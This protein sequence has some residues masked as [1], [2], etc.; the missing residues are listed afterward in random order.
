MPR[1]IGGSGKA[2]ALLSLDASY[3]DS[4]IRDLLEGQGVRDSIG[5]S[6]QWVLLDDFGE[7]EKVPLEA[8]R[9]RVEPFDPRDDGYAEKLRSF[10]VSRGKRRLFIP[11]R[12][13]M[14]DRVGA[15]LKNIPFSLEVLTAPRSLLL[16]ALLFLVAAA[17]TL[18][19]SAAPLI[20]ALFLPLWAVLAGMGVPGF[21]LIAAQ[22]AL[23]RLLGEPVREYFISR[24]YEKAA[25]ATPTEVGPTSVGKFPAPLATEFPA[26]GGSSPASLRKLFNYF[27]DFWVLG[28]VFLGAC[29]AIAILGGLGPLIFLLETVFFLFLLGLSLWSESNRGANQG[30]IRFLP[31]QITDIALKPPLY[32]RIL[33][34]FALA[35]LALLFLGPLFNASSAGT[36]LGRGRDW[37]T[38]RN[39]NAEIYRKHGEFQSQFSFLP[40]YNTAPGQGSGYGR[41]SLGTDGLIA[42]LPETLVFGETVASSVDAI[43]PFPLEG[44]IDFLD[45][46]SY[47]DGGMVSPAGGVPGGSGHG[48]L[49]SALIGLGLCIPLIFWDRRGHSTRGKLSKYMDKRIAA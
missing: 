49:F 8:Y 3:P 19:F 25:L 28:A 30:H 24:R 39:I 35:S 2:Y 6:T 1:S 14:E 41:Y 45:H 9:D 13:G 15:A 48:D 7:M 20:T 47:T 23:S 38:R 42:G 10:F 32:S 29:G 18:F 40:L 43:P 22:A 16:P 26:Q 5:E 44:L 21:A 34:P 11:L 33:F 27:R 46:Y 37:D 31:V 12:L 36:S 17:I 4:L